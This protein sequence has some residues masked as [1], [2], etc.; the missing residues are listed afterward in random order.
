MKRGEIRW[1]KF[2]RPDKKAGSYTD[3]RFRAAIS[4]GSDYRSRYE[5]GP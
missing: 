5:Y 3:K 4:W 1:Y 2:T